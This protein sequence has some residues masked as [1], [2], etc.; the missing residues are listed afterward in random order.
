MRPYMCLAPSR[1]T[2]K[3]AAGKFFKE[4]FV[5]WK[6]PRLLD[7]RGRT[8]NKINKASVLAELIGI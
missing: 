8:E 2:N 5:G 1:P 4:I 7:T 6:F 3:V